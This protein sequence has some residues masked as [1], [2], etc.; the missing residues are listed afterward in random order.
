MKSVF[1]VGSFTH[2]ITH[3]VTS[4]VAQIAPTSSPYV[5]V[6]GSINAHEPARS[7]DTYGHFVISVCVMVTS[8]R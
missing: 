5:G 8:D 6:I 7:K 3:E 2:G 4:E 1:V